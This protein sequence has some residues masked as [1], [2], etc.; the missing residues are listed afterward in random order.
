MRL[1]RR[2]S[3]IGPQYLLGTGT[4]A[5]AVLKVIGALAVLLAA[6]MLVLRAN[7]TERRG[8]L[9]AGGIGLAGFLIALLLIP[10]GVDELITR[11]VIVVLIPLIV[12]IAGGLGA[13]RARSLGLIGAAALCVVGLVAT[14]GVL[15][16]QRY[17]RPDWRAVAHVIGPRPP[18]GAGRA[19]LL[20]QYPSV[21]PLE[22]YVPG[23][24]F[25]DK[26]GG[27]VDEVDVVARPYP[28][29][30]WF[31]WWGSTC[32]I[33]PSNVDTA[34]RIPGFHA[35]GP[36]IHAGQLRVLRLVSAKPVQ[37]TPSQV[38]RGLTATYLVWDGLLYQPGK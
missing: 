19:I 20:Q 3:Q 7:R 24:R 35:A 32:N 18:R 9:L 25:M 6:A 11:N 1:D 36:V 2:L 26:Q 12:L 27:K 23:L 8:A 28:E 14:I 15:A 10:L 29:I 16:D 34:I 30:G 33:K 31:C 37:L 38:S 4:P 5:R 22:L 17:Q 13:R 21:L